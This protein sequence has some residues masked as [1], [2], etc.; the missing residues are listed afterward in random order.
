MKMV[1]T[2]DIISSGGKMRYAELQNNPGYFAGED[3]VI[4][5]S[6]RGGLRA[7]KSHE[8]E[9]GYLY[10]GIAGGTHKRVHR[11]VYEAFNGPIPAGLQIN[12]ID[13]NKK[14]NAISNLEAVTQSENFKHAFRT[15]LKKQKKG[16]E[17]CRAKLK[18]EQVDYIRSRYA[19][20]G[21][22]QKELGEQFGLR[23][24]YI[25][26]ILKGERW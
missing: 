15:G 25:C 21:I 17:S 23:Q 9:T 18:Q 16:E 10:I 19:K 4:Y 13:G 14:N 7:M 11:L 8:I 5:S 1:T 24:S 6:K 2:G 22:T 26:L 12:H 20:G 3:G